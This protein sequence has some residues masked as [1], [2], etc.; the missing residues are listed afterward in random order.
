MDL[1][2]ATL[3]A[4]ARWRI[5]E[6]LALPMVCVKL[7]SNN[8]CELSDDA[9][10]AVLDGGMTI[11]VV[12]ADILASSLKECFGVLYDLVMDAWSDPRDPTDEWIRSSGNACRELKLEKVGAMID[13]SSHALRNSDEANRNESLARYRACV[14]GIYYGVELCDCILEN[15]DNE[16]LLSI[17]A[18]ASEVMRPLLDDSVHAIRQQTIAEIAERVLRKSVESANGHCVLRGY[19]TDGTF[20]Q[21][22]SQKQ[23]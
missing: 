14:E 12:D 18:G 10:V 1:T 23:V 21:L 5:G 9:D 20:D 11:V 17:I 15:S 22:L 3:I 4:D 2:D 19:L 6:A 13:E 8:D 7:V 16:D